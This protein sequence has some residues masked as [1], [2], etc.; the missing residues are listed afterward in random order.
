L[1]EFAIFVFDAYYIRLHS[2]KF[3]DVFLTARKKMPIHVPIVKEI[4]LL[5][6]AQYA[7]FGSLKNPCFNEVLKVEILLNTRAIH[8]YSSRA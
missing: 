4:H 5:Q 7:F 6:R 8:T 3:D 2:V 1:E